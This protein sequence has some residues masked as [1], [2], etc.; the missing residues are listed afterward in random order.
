MNIAKSKI[1]FYAFVQNKIMNIILSNPNQMYQHKIGIEIIL[2]ILN[3][4]INKNEPLLYEIVTQ[5]HYKLFEC[6]T[7]PYIIQTQ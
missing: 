4:K 6:Q 5:L 3:A 7:I 1:E 2:D